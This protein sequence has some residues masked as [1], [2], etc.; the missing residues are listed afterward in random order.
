MR[1][2]K[3]KDS[4]D[5]IMTGKKPHILKPKAEAEKDS[6][7]R[8]RD[9]FL[10]TRA[11]L[12]YVKKYAL[13]ARISPLGLV[14]G[15]LARVSALT[16]P[17]VVVQLSDANLSMGLNLFIVLVGK[18]GTGKGKI[19]SH[20]SRLIPAPL[21]IPLVE[22][23]PKTGESIPAKF[24]R[25]IPRVDEEGKTVKGEYE[26]EC[27]TDRGLLFI[28]EIS[29]LGA[30]MKSQGS[31]ILPT[32]LQAYSNEGIG[33]DTKNLEFQVKLPP[34]S[35]RLSGI[36]GAQPSKASIIFD[37]TDVGLAGR[38]LYMPSTD[39]YA[40]KEAGPA[41][42]PA[43]FP[44]K[45]E[46]LPDSV[47]LEK[48]KNLCDRGTIKNLPRGDEGYPLIVLQAPPKAKR[49]VDEANWLSVRG[50]AIPLDSHRIENVGKIAALFA[51][52]ENRLIINDEDWGLAKRFMRISDRT[53]TDCMGEKRARELEQ[54]A[55]SLLMKEEAEVKKEE[56]KVTRLCTRIVQWL[57]DSGNSGM[58]HSEVS[59]KTGRD[60]DYFDKAIQRLIAEKTIKGFTVGE[61][62]WYRLSK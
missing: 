62:Q 47:G 46:R 54:K 41:A 28:P 9:E 32:L 4:T 25:R 1:D 11:W 19:M 17:N 42:D 58:N 15:V 31:V 53:R 51:L 24:L 16:P 34:Y 45:A 37:E 10:D 27:L 7:L 61:A 8:E 3:P 38:F 59:R 44:F 60:H 12:R 22:M 48:M 55:D 29:S 2:V 23:N 21:T 26:S 39:P 33:G 5:G 49:E 56:M 14:A 50:D 18:P 30:A 57:K 20:S 43:G 52:M 13:A 36:I 6:F 40:P 35:Y